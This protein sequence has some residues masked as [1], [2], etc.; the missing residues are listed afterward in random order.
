MTEDEVV[1][2]L[3]RQCLGDWLMLHDV[4]WEST[5]DDRSD[6]AKRRTAEVLR[7]LFID[8]LMVPGELAESGFVDWPGQPSEWLV[9]AQSDLD[10][11]N[12]K[13][14]GAGFW[15]RLTETGQAVARAT[16]GG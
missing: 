11:L 15:L 3:L 12:W 4:L 9:R 6:D 5:H 16:R 10:R 8:G 7:R 1:E 13:P 14:M 2:E